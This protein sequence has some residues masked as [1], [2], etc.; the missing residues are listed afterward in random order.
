VVTHRP[1]DEAWPV[2]HTSRCVTCVTF[3]PGSAELRERST[4]GVC[5]GIDN[6]TNQEGVEEVALGETGRTAL[7]DALPRLY[8]FGVVLTSDLQDAEDL[9]HDGIE[10]YVRRA[11]VNI[12]I[13]QAKRRATLIRL[14]PKVAEP[15]LEVSPGIGVRDRPDLIRVLR[16]LTEIERAVLALRYMADLSAIEV[17]HTLGRPVGTIRRITHTALNKMRASEAFSEMRSNHES[18]S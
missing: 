17:C 4:A 3:S 1:L 7:I 10:G 13:N 9:V 6:G 15:R 18:T 14:L 11:M 12:H 5:V 16:Q 8:R 2:F